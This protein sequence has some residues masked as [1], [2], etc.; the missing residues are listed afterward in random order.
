MGALGSMNAWLAGFFAFAA[1]HY[2]ILWWLSR[3]E[4]V[5]L[6][7]SV[8]CALYTAFCVARVALSRATTIPDVQAGL[9][10]VMILG[11]LVHVVL[12]QFY[13][14]VSSRR[15]RAFRGILTAAFV[16]LAVLNLFMP[17]RGTVLALRSTPSPGGGVSFA[18]ICTPPGV[19]LALYYLAS[20]LSEGYGFVVARALWRRDRSGAV[21]VAVAASA[22]LLGTAISTLVDFAKLPMPYLGALPHTAFVLCMGFFLA[23]EYSA[24]GARV[25]TTARQF[26]AVFER[27]PIAKALLAPD[28]RLLRVN[29]AF[30]HLLG[31]TAE[32]LGARRLFDI[33]PDGEGSIE[34]QVRR[35]L[36]GEV[37]AFT[38]EQR[39]VRKEGEPIWVLLVVSAVPDDRGHSAQ[40]I[41]L[42]QDVTEVRAYRE[43][44][45]NVVATRTRELREAKNEAERASQAKSLFL[46]HMS[47][48][49]R[50]PL[51][52]MLLNAVILKTDPSLGAEQLKWVEGIQKSGKHLTAILNNV[53]EM[54]KVEAG[55]LTLVED[56]FDLGTTLD[57]VVEMFAAEAASNGTELRVEPT[58]GL[59][60][61]LLGD[62]GKVKQILIN[63]VSNAAKFTRQG[64]IRITAT[65]S[66]FADAAILV[67]IV[68]ADTGVGIAEHDRARMFQPFEQ[69]DGGAKA[70]GTG[71]GLAISLAYARLMGGDLAVES[72][73]GA[74][75]RFTLTFTARVAGPEH[76]R[77]ASGP[78]NAAAPAAAG[79]WRVLIV[80]DMG[81]NRDAVAELLARNAFE[82]R[83][84]AD[85][86]TGLAIH[87][88]WNPDVVLMDLRMP[89]MN[90][91]EA[92]RWLRAGG[93]RA[94]IGALT[95]GAFGDDEGE[96]LRA[97]A[98]FFLRKPFNDRELLDSVA[99]VLAAHGA[100]A[101]AVA[102][103]RTGG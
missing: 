41:A 25:S 6:V 73:P 22:I 74:G 55:R 91:L 19:A 49:I 5:L 76:A 80:D 32:E 8:Q 54:S 92:I 77:Q 66:A 2:A 15:D 27:S 50:S 21:L 36:A 101:R 63:L 60:R 65:G 68:V 53:L 16:A 29:H 23:R 18:P 14:R 94:V 11:P 45:E 57:E 40:M 12:L 93:S 99:R 4:R 37:R 58:S 62:G 35:L 102:P 88:V 69:L 89:G 1:V 44:L 95:A 10:R 30:N 64:S 56:R 61:S 85:G 100:T 86:A 87:A 47:H 79:R 42:I 39:L 31:S 71:L 38:V 103:S 17:L 75:S 34:A 67:E 52:V 78:I 13:A 96:A 70:G 26:E 90:G 9:V 98:D 7:F 97:G 28:G 72:A 51:Q 81:G 43:R 83:T 48:E 3:S 33:F 20:A 82:T 24:R 59:P 46:A 84:A